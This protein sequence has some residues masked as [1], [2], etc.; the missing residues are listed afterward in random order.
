MINLSEA[1]TKR[2]YII[3]KINTEEDI[4]KRLMILGMTKGTTVYVQNKKNNG[5]L[6]IKVRGIRIGLEKE[7]AKNIIVSNLSV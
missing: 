3:I 2:N 6:I 7:I 5:D 4:K 1:I